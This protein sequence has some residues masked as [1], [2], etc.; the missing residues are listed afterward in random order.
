MIAHKCLFESPINRV[1]VGMDNSRNDASDDFKRIIKENSRVVQG[2]SCS[3]FVVFVFTCIAL[4][5]SHN[6]LIY[7]ACGHTLRNLLIADI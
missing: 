1:G 6:D 5:H 3:V 2:C 7:S 4:R